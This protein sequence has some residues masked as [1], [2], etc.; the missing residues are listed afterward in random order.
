L[1][2]FTT[3]AADYIASRPDYPDALFDAL[4]LHC[5]LVPGETIVDIGAGTGPLT[6]GFLA[7][8]HRV[9]AI[10]P[11]T[12]MRSACDKSLERFVGYQSLS[13]TAES[14]P[15]PDGS[16]DLITAAQAF[17]WFDAHHARTEALRVLRPTGN[18]ALIWN[19][20]AEDDPLQIALNAVFAQYGE[21]KRHALVAHE[22]RA[23][24]PKFFGATHPLEITFDHEHRLDESGLQ[25]LVFSRSYMPARDTF[26]GMAVTQQIRE[27]FHRFASGE[28]VT[29]R[30]TT[31]AILG[32][33]S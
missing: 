9:I 32:R 30:Y 28:I 33:P 23:D 16:V 8:G 14:L 24:V 25:S 21:A 27:I 6:A 12:A 22:D 18:V 7:R 19:D 11:N 15:L 1:E 4:H 13:G 29:I 20:R 31:L 10:E 17:H 26:A 2:I 5:G 3:K